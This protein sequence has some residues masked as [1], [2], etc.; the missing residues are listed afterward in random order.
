MPED[1]RKNQK[2]RAYLDDIIKTCKPGSILFTEELS[3]AL[4]TKFR[5][6]TNRNIGLALRERDDVELRNK[7]KFGTWVVK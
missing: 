2:T 6:V 1:L 4:S 7:D 5:S 3:R